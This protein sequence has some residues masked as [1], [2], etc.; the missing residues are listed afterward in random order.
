MAVPTIFETCRP[1]EDVRA[2][3][4]I[5]AALDDV[6]DDA[7][8][9]EPLVTMKDLDRVIG[10]PELLRPDTRIQPLGNREYGF[11]RPGSADPVRVT[12]D[13]DHYRE[14]PDS[15]ELWS[16]GNRLFEPPGP[17]DDARSPDWPAGTTLKDVLDD[18]AT[19]D[20]TAKTP[21]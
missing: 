9:P 11:T 13:P 18:G 7:A 4:D 6:L 16:P 21:R 19:E 14:H 8:Q 2:G 3:F 5:D 17:A 20:A 15:V 12:T 1:R 10:S